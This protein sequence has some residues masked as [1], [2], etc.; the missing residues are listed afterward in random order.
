MI[1]SGEEFKMEDDVR[2]TL[3]RLLKLLD[4]SDVI[5]A[6]KQIEERVTDHPKLYAMTEEI[7]AIQKEAVKCA[8]YGKPEAEKQAIKRADQLTQA[9]DEEPLVIRYREKLIEAN[10]L[11]QH[12]TSLL[13]RTVNVKLELAYE[14]LFKQP[15]TETQEPT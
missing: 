2:Q 13:E 4:D 11:L 6:Y 15:S 7:K 9:F 3:D 14:D 8:H 1:R 12:I 10:D 5:Q